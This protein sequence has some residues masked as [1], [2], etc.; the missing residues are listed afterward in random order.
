MDL[1]VI[2]FFPDSN[3][4]PKQ[5]LIYFRQEKIGSFEPF[6]LENTPNYNWFTI[7][8][9]DLDGDG[10]QDILVGTYTRDDLYKAPTSNWSPFV[11][12][13]NTKK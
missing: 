2:S 11:I 8:Q 12:L 3:E 5:D 6:I 10:D 7:T 13:R 1:F 9:G 4:V